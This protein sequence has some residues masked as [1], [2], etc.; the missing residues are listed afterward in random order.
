MAK[1]WLDWITGKSEEN[2]DR[3][4]DE[5]RDLPPIQAGDIDP[6]T[7]AVN[8]VRFAAILEGEQAVHPGVLLVVDLDDRSAAIEAIAEDHR[9]DILPWLAQSIKQA[10]RADD[11]VTHLHGYAFAV[12]LRGAPQAIAAQLASRIRESVDDTLF[13]TASGIARLGVAVS[14][15][16]YPSE[17]AGEGGLIEEAL[18]GL[19]EAKNSDSQI[20]IS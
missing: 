13:M 18:D 8:W 11:L 2:W 14:G 5:A 17:K 19:A 10:V 6:T 20:V 7:G 9:A 16:S 3:R 15:V 12:L 1:S 4:S